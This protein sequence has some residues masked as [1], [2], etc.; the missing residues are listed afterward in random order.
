MN[1]LPDLRGFALAWATATLLAGFWLWTLIGTPAQ[2]GD[3]QQ[4]AVRY[5]VSLA[6]V[7]LPCAMA[8]AA[9][10]WWGR[11]AW[12]ARLL[13]GGTWVYAGVFKVLGLTPAPWLA[14]GAAVLV[15]AWP[16]GTRRA[17]TR[18]EGMLLLLSLMGTL[19]ALGFALTAARYLAPLGWGA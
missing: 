15:T 10:L 5:L 1:A 13:L 6:L 8:C 12:V 17:V 19:T 16:V 7:A 9:L 14:L 11:A 4:L 3:P 2:L 18:L